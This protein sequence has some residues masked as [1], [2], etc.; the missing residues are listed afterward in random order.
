MFLLVSVARVKQALHIDDDE[1][2]DIIGLYTSAASH[3][4]VTYL[5]GQAGD[6]LGIDSPPDSPPN[7]LTSIDERV[8]ASVIML[9]GTIYREPDG[10]EAKNFS[11][12]NLPHYVTALLYPLRDP[13]L[14]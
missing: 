11:L 5:K 1:M 9:V 12:G 6:F 2:D 3:A 8:V 4:V 14:A 13:T 7:D 10:D